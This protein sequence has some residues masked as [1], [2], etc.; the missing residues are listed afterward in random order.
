MPRK[1]TTAA[2]ELVVQVEPEDLDALRRDAERYRWLRA[3]AVRVNGSEMWWSGEYLD[4]RVD[5]G[6]AHADEPLRAE[7]VKSKGRRLAKPSPK[8]K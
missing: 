4:T 1:S 5:T 6:L 2:T 3:R 7:P 8:L